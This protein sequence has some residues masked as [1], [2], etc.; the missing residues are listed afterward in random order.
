M[1][2]AVGAPASSMW[3]RRPGAPACP[4]GASCPAG[5]SLL[6]RESVSCGGDSPVPADVAAAAVRPGAPGE[7]GRGGGVGDPSAGGSGVPVSAPRLRVLGGKAQQ[8]PGGPADRRPG[9]LPWRA[10]GR[11]GWARDLGREAPRAPR[12]PVRGRGQVPAVC[13][14]VALR[15][16]L[17]S[18]AAAGPCSSPSWGG[19]GRGP[20]TRSRVSR[21]RSRGRKCPE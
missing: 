9:D 17:R 19:G 11:R 14:P 2:G 20:G 6:S 5:G 15:P 10:E 8:P 3:H 12:G 13:G 1:D 18:S 21:S 16:R 4:S 7:A